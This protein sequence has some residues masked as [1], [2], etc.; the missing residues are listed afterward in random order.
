MT[1]GMLA[2]L[3]QSTLLA[4]L[5]AGGEQEGNQPHRTQPLRC[6]KRK[7]P[8]RLLPRGPSH[9]VQKTDICCTP[10][11]L[12]PFAGFPLDLLLVASCYQESAGLAARLP[13]EKQSRGNK[14]ACVGMRFPP[15]PA[16]P[17]KRFFH[18]DILNE[19]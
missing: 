8:H 13:P 9:P 11:A 4:L 3:I 18:S 19:A 16:A 14:Q 10:T 12:R 17:A 15:G 5:V 2:H 7:V 1:P 6:R